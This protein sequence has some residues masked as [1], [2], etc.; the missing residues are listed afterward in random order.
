MIQNFDPAAIFPVLQRALRPGDRLLF[1]ANL[2]PGEDYEEGT[3]RILPLYDN[4]LTRN[5]V[6]QPLLDWGIT[7]AHG[8]LHFSLERDRQ[9]LLRVEARFQFTRETETRVHGEPLRFRAGEYIRMFYSYRHTPASVRQL[10]GQAE[11]EQL[12]EWVSASGEEG[13]FLAGLK[14][15]PKS[16]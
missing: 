7:E 4:P 13:V 3:K 8:E 9:G 15:T 6:R 2:A 16:T 14:E 10:L 12:G 11:F 5:W 1:S